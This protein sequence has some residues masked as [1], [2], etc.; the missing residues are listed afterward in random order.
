VSKK[1]GPTLRFVND[2]VLPLDVA[3]VLIQRLKAALVDISPDEAP[4]AYTHVFGVLMVLERALAD[5]DALIQLGD[6]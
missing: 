3:A 6:E 2:R 4:A 5:P 1:R